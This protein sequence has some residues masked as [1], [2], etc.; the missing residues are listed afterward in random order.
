MAHLQAYPPAL[1]VMTESFEVPFHKIEEYKVGATIERDFAYWRILDQWKE[2]S[3]ATGESRYY[4][5]AG[6]LPHETK[7]EPVKDVSPHD[8]SPA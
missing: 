1:G 3:H 4:V 6:K 5:T 7:S 2:Y 8:R